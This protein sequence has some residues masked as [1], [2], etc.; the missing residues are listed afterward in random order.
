MIAFA[1]AFASCPATTRT[2]PRISAMRCAH[3]S[4]SLPGERDPL[5]RQQIAIPSQP[6]K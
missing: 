5:F 1:F 3:A 2:Q 6:E 4:A